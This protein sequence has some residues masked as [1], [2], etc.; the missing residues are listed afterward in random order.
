MILDQNKF[1]VLVKPKAILCLLP[2]TQLKG[3]LTNLFDII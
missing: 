1:D 2:I 3:D